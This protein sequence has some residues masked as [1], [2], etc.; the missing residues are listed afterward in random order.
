MCM[1]QIYVYTCTLHVCIYIDTAP[2]AAAHK[3]MVAVMSGADVIYLFIYLCIHLYVCIHLDM[4][5]HTIYVYTCRTRD[6][7]Y[8]DKTPN[9]AAHR[10]MAAG[11]TGA[12]VIDFSYMCMKTEY[13]Y[14]CTIHIYIHV[15]KTVHS[16]AHKTMDAVMSGADVI[17]L[18]IY[19]Y[20]VY[21]CIYMDN[22]FLYLCRRNSACCCS[23][24]QPWQRSHQAQT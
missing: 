17:N 2:N 6:C 20:E 16:A 15:A 12:D 1:H 3:T 11:I 9:A 21:K 13:V 7:I 8:M 18:F 10:T 14:T 19:V 5:I 23:Q 24:D 22:T 4:C